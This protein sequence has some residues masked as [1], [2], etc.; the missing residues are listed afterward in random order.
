MSAACPGCQAGAPVEL[1]GPSEVTVGTVAVLLERTPAVT[2]P[3]GHDAVPPDVV[4]AAMRAT[5]TAVARARSRFLRDDVCGNCGSGLTMPVRRTTRAVTV[6]PEATSILT[7]HFDLPMSRCPN[8]GLDQL[9]SRSQ[10]DLVVSVPA[11]FAS[12]GVV[13]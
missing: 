3:Q 6:E 7:L 5:E 2:C 12:S 1:R 11:V 4:D 10:E 9:P 8:C 13:P